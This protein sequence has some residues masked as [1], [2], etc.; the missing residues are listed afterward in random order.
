M[1]AP[2]TPKPDRLPPS[3][4]L[5][6]LTASQYTGMSYITLARLVYIMLPSTRPWALIAPLIWWALPS[7]QQSKF[8]AEANRIPTGM[9]Y[10]E[11]FVNIYAKN[12]V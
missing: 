1:K 12:S 7:S 10:P 9:H 3:P 5:S 2:P 4:D 11:K 8:A 6:P